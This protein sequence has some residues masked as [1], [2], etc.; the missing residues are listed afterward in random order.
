MLHSGAEES[1]T[2]NFQQKAYYRI[3]D[4]QGNEKMAEIA[5]V[6]TPTKTWL[7]AKG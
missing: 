7:E 6:I 1:G 4:Q 5:G 2:G 3:D